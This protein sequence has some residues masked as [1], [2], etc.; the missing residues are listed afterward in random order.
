MARRKKPERPQTSISSPCCKLILRFVKQ[1][2]C[3]FHLGKDGNLKFLAYVFV[4]V[5]ECVCVRVCVRV[6]VLACV[7]VRV[8]C[9]CCLF[10]CLFVVLWLLLLLLLL[11]LLSFLFFFFFFSSFFS[12][13]SFFFLF[14]FLLFIFFFFFFLSSFLSLWVV[15][16]ACAD[17][18]F[19]V[20]SFFVFNDYNTKT[21]TI[22]MLC[23]HT[24]RPCRCST[25]WV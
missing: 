15:V 18:V 3:C 9:V 6:C 14:L 10:V 5:Y 21:C 2:E 19:W 16:L 1:A 24:K 20:E 17:V 11:L 23:T 25:I 4:S 8:L 12:S 22:N 13:F 7:R